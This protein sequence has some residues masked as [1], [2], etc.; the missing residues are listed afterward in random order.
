MRVW[1]G[2]A[3]GALVG[4]LIG[5]SQLLCPDGSCAITGSWFGGSILGGFGGTFLAS[6][7]PFGGSAT[8]PAEP[9]DTDPS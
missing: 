1:I 7:I 3:I 8:T 4:G 2:L 5:Y 9:P 6:V